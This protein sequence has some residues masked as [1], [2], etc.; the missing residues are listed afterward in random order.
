MLANRSLTRTP[1]RARTAMMSSTRS[2]VVKSL[3]YYSWVGIFRNML[4][5]ARYNRIVHLCNLV[6]PSRL[7]L[8]WVPVGRADLPSGLLQHAPGLCF[9]SRV[10]TKQAPDGML[11]Y[12]IL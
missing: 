6:V 11:Y 9:E 2:Y 1:A 12:S 10:R 3:R 8:P 5:V 4:N 7:R